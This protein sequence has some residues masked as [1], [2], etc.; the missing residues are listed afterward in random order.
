MDLK[1]IFCNKI[2]TNPIPNSTADKTKK[3]KVNERRL[4]LSTRNPTERTITYKVIHS[5]S[6]TNNKCNELEILKEILN[7]IKKKRTKYMLTS[8]INTM[9]Y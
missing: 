4:I 2:I 6:A 5:N 7:K 9:Y 8:P 3:K 1:K